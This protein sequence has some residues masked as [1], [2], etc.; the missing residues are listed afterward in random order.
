M[1]LAGRFLLP[2]VSYLWSEGGQISFLEKKKLIKKVLSEP[3]FKILLLLSFSEC[4]PASP[5]YD[6]IPLWAHYVVQIPKRLFRIIWSAFSLWLGQFLGDANSAAKHSWPGSLCVLARAVY[7]SGTRTQT[8]ESKAH[9]FL[10]LSRVQV[11]SCSIQQ[12]DA[13]AVYKPPIGCLSLEQRRR[14]TIKTK[15]SF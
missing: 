1:N 6:F 11:R 12:L 14:I 8:G 13:Y 4:V 5:H 2:I 7:P 15:P 3:L 9:S 10:Q